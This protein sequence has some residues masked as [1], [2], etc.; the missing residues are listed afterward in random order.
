M[1]WQ[2]RGYEQSLSSGPSDSFSSLCQTL[3]ELEES[4]LKA[5]IHL[6]GFIKTEHKTQCKHPKKMQD[7]DPSRTLYC[8]KCGEDV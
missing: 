5:V 4:K 2:I 1:K 7:Y 3:K 6:I 8:M